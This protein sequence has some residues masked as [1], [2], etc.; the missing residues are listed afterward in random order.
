MR[1]RGNR[2]RVVAVFEDVRQDGLL[3]EFQGNI[4]RRDG[5]WEAQDPLLSEIPLLR[6]HRRIRPV[7][8]FVATSAF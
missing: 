7:P 3:V 1:D 4:G 2:N 8:G 5:G 6:K